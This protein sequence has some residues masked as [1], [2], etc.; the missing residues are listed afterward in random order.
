MAEAPAKK[1][2]APS[3]GG[4]MS[5]KV[6]GV[7]LPIIIVG[8]LVAAIV[9]YRKIKGSSSSTA[10]T[11]ATGADTSGT[12]TSGTDAGTSDGSSGGGWSGG[13]GSTGAGG[14][15]GS[16]RGQNSGF[17]SLLAQIATLQTEVGSLVNQG[18]QVS[19]PHTVPN[20]KGTDILK[21][22]PKPV[23][24][25][26]TL[27]TSGPSIFTAAQAAKTKTNAPVKANPKLGQAGVEPTVKQTTTGTTPAK[28]KVGTGVQGSGLKNSGL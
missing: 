4:L 3:S 17:S 13:G 1:K 15:G 19:L 12:G 21:V 20:P 26:P 7:P 22:T 18:S 8:G 16:G 9:I 25:K 10:A 28:A 14:G 24:A 5:K 6:G 23:S 11:T 2:A 27:V